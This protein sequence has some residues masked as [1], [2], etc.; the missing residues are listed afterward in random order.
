MI[1]AMNHIRVTGNKVLRK[2]QGQSAFLSYR[3]RYRMT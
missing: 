2:E 1:T 3:I